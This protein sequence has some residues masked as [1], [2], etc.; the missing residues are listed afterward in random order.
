MTSSIW[1]LLFNPVK[2]AWAKYLIFVNLNLDQYVG[3]GA[4]FEDMTLSF[5]LTVLAVHAILFLGISFWVFK[6]RDVAA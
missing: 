1:T 2:Y 3:G 4:R 6:K 5:S